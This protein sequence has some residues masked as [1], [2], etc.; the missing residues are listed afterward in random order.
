METKENSVELIGYTLIKP[1]IVSFSN[2]TKLARLNIKTENSAVFNILLINE[3]VELIEKDLAIGT[4]IAI[5]GTLI[6]YTYKNKL[7]EEKQEI[8]ILAKRL[9]VL[10]PPEKIPLE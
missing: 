10:T 7:G 9:K 8:D 3:D 2:E 5:K 6:N 4:K 1:V